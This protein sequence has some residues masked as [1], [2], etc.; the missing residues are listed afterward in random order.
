MWGEH[1][2]FW[3]FWQK[4]KLFKKG[5]FRSLSKNMPVPLAPFRSLKKNL[6]RSPAMEKGAF[7]K[8]SLAMKKV[9]S[10]PA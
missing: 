10:Y 4:N 9:S 2:E 7:T 6:D 5:E 3:F 1:R 8:D